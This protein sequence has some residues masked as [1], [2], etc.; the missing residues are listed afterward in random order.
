MLYYLHHQKHSGC[1]GPRRGM[2]ERSYPTPDVRGGRPSGAITCRR[3]RVAAERSNPTSKEQ[4]LPGCRRAERSYFMFK[5]RRGGREKIPLVQG[6]EQQL[7][8]AGAASKTYPTSKV[9]ETQVRG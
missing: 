8:F 2:A 4:R 5:I 7:C 3:S 9:R 1:D 6:K